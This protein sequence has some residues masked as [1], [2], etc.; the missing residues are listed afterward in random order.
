[1]KHARAS[2]KAS[3]EI[4]CQLC[5]GWVLAREK[6]TAA[7]RTTLLTAFSAAR[8]RGLLREQV[9]ALEY[10]A[11]AFLLADPTEASLMKVALFIR[12]G[13]M[14]AHSLAP[15]GDL[16]LELNIREALLSLVL[17]DLPCALLQ[18]KEAA[19]HARRADMPWEEALAR[20]VAGMALVHIGRSA[21]G[22]AVLRESLQGL[23]RIRERL[24]SAITKAWIDSVEGNRAGSYADPDSANMYRS[25][26][27]QA[28]GYPADSAE[29]KS[30][31]AWISHPRLGPPRHPA[32]QEHT[33]IIHIDRAAAIASPHD[34][35]DI[36][37]TPRTAIGGHPKLVNAWRDL[38]LVTRAP[39]LVDTLRLAEVFSP[40]RI[41]V[42]I[43]GETGTGKDLVAQGI[44]RLSAR[45]GKY[46]PINCAAISKDV[47]IAELFGTTKGAYTGAT[48]P[49]PGLL[50][51]AQHGTLFLDEVADL[52]PEAQGY[53]LRFLDTGEVRPIG[54]AASLP[55]DVR[56][57][58][59]TAVNLRERVASGSFRP[60]LFS[61]LTG[62][63]LTLPPLRERVE[64]LELL[65][66]LLWARLGGQETELNEIL[67]VDMLQ[68]LRKKPW[69]GNVR[70]LMHA[71]SRALPLLRR[72]G[73]KDA[74]DSLLVDCASEDV[75]VSQDSRDEISLEHYGVPEHFRGIP[76]LDNHSLCPLYRVL[77]KDPRGKWPREV[78]LSA[79]H[80]AHGRVSEAAKILGVSRSQAYRL[81][82]N[83]RQ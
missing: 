15:S 1:M 74:T 72:M 48:H 35:R 63:I 32:T 28:P 45:S 57:V 54:S 43:L 66:P 3:I 68:S 17:G 25:A 4:K 71:L 26:A 2:G 41:P 52:S 20:R 62:I 30:V 51:E 37:S 21:E 44:H 38:G 69:P 8:N 61:R 34:P 6:E 19:E 31:R 10:L 33:S 42:L 65:I 22:L 16:A 9:L 13:K 75:H 76:S 82:R 73:S 49:R 39:K 59:A 80:T 67:S 70:E 55:V 60:D 7:A 78:L 12:T 79:L 46:I 64:D 81:Y 83:L 50:R 11:D 56:V 18:A 77:A 5:L 23:E 53:L 27:D 36:A 58:S 29:G 24:E 47:F 40:E 14:L